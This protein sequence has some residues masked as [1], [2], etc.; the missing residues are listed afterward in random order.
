MDTG[1]KITFYTYI[2]IVNLIELWYISKRILPELFKS[3]TF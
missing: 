3:K 2:T 1:F